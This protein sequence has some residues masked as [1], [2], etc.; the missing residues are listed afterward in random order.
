MLRERSFS[1][2]NGICC[3]MGQ[4]ALSWGEVHSR[5]AALA[6]ELEQA[7][8]PILIYGPKSP[9][10]VIAIVGCFWA[11]C[12]YV[13]AGPHIPP[14][15]IHSMIEQAHID[16]SIS[17]SPLPQELSGMVNEITLPQKG[18]DQYSFPVVSR[19][20]AAYILFTSG[21]T[22]MPKGVV[23]TYANLEN[24]ISW[25]ITRPAIA[26][27]YTRSVLNQ[28]QFTFD[29]SVAD[30]FYTLY[31]GCTLELIQEDVPVPESGSRAELAVMTP[32]FA[33]YCLMNDRF[34]AAALPCLQTIFFCGEPLRGNTVRR[35]WRRFPGL[36]I[37]NAYGPTEAT[38]A[39]SAAEI[40][41]ELAEGETLPIGMQQ[42]E[43]V[44]IIIADNNCILLR[45][46]SV[47][48]GYLGGNK[49]NGSFMTGDRG[50][51]SNGY[52]WYDGRCDNQIKYKGYRVEP[53]EIE[54][55]LVAQPEVRQAVVIPHRDK[56]GRVLSLKALVVAERK[57]Q[58]DMLRYELQ[59][60]LPD[61]MIPKQIILC[62]SVP[63]TKNGKIDRR[64]A[65][66]I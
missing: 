33:D 16:T 1:H 40:T 55:V 56:M 30:L 9:E 47:A 54:T 37:I 50:H 44:D 61:Y 4:H 25:F 32:S 21:S 49:F 19:D 15:R 64:K 12:T 43:A 10:Y 27:L 18:T 24:F 22:G 6:K 36:R 2:Q 65:E 28:A 41:P 63:L 59:K 52:L 14:Q 45:G 26:G 57:I 23:V 48:R 46:T 38:C 62:E 31:M 60:V 66:Q 35:L 3:R 39:I 42:G 53:E 5:A 7:R 58:E 34:H 11:G 13:P 29:L 17:L 20:G 51:F 8:G